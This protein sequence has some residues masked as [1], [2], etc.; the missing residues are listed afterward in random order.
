[1][2]NTRIDKYYEQI[3]QE[4]LGIAGDDLA[5]KLLVYAEADD[6]AVSADLFYCA[7][8]GAVR[9]RLGSKELRALVYEFWQAWRKEPGKHE[10]KV[11]CY[12]VE[13]GKFH[14]ELG[15]PDQLDPEE[16]ISDRRPISAKRCFGDVRIDYSSPDSAA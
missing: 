14:I 13:G 9:F 16:H 6:G 1:M 8:D 2:A 15:Y 5:G 12:L 4:A 7:K 10:W 11:L 3:G